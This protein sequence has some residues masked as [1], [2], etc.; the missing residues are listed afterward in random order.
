[1]PNKNWMFYTAYGVLVIGAGLA[2][3]MSERPLSSTVVSW[4]LFSLNAAAFFFLAPSVMN[5]IRETKEYKNNAEL[6]KELQA[7]KKNIEAI[8][9]NPAPKISPASSAATQIPSIRSSQQVLTAS[10]DNIFAKPAVAPVQKPAAPQQI[11]LFAQTSAHPLTPSPMEGENITRLRPATPTNGTPDA[12]RSTSNSIAAPIN[13]SDVPSEIH[14]VAM[15]PTESGGSRGSSLSAAA[16]AK[17]EAHGIETPE[18]IS[19]TSPVSPVETSPAPEITSPTGSVS[20]LANI[21]VGEDDVLC[22]RGEGAGLNWQEGIPMSYDGGDHWSWKALD[23]SQPI[24]CRIYLN[25]EISAFG[26]DIELKPG[27][28]IEVAPSFPKVEA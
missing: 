10:L 18:N 9:A 25:D 17:E 5:F 4:A 21:Q 1:M 12:N 7:I 8:T 13:T 20:I 6:L 23:I 3:F 19:E 22:I 15:T 16:L 28:S 24:T 14:R 26:E 2:L 11:S 27:Q